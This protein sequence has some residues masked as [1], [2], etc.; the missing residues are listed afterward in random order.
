MY[1]T[2]V[3]GYDGTERAL[4]AVDEASLIATAFGA[5]LHLVTAVAKDELHEFGT[6]S[7]RVVLSD[8]EMANQRLKK[9]AKSYS[10]LD[11]SA[12]AVVSGVANALLTEAV[13][14]NADVIVVG[15]KNVQGLSRVLGSVAEDVAHNAQCAVLIAQTSEKFSSVQ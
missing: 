7:D 1:K 14:V 13:A 10:H 5:S 11:V 12:S 9:L 2:I 6:G 3:V 15:N 4:R 8:V